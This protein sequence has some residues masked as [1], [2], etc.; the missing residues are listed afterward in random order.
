MKILKIQKNKILFGNG[1]EFSLPRVT[2]KEYKLS[3]GMEISDESYMLLAE[4]SALSFSYWLLSKRDYSTK[5]LETK[6]LTKYKEKTIISKM[7]AKLNDMCYL[8]DYDFAKS[9]IESH[10][11][12]GN[13]KIE[14]HLILKGIKSSTIRELLNDNIENEILEIQKL[15][16]RMKDKEYRKKV[17]SL[18]RKGFEYGTIKKAIENLK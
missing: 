7:I 14:Y 10:K 9:F 2:I 3:E 18:M 13:K 11:S 15:W 16:E 12:W 6:L 4:S 8:N 1:A 5:E 17:E